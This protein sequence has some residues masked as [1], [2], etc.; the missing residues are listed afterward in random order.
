MTAD[1]DALG[2]LDNDVYEA[3]RHPEPGGSW[4]VGLTTKRVMKVV[5]LWLVEHDRQ[6][7]AAALRDLS[8]EIYQLRA[9][10]RAVGDAT[11]NEGIDRASKL[12]GARAEQEGT[13]P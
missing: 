9:S 8:R 7:R 3:I 1:R 10:G 2:D 5:S 12:A 4:T 6:V 11:F 13:Q